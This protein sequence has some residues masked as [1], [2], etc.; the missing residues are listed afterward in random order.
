[1]DN[2]SS[3]QNAKSKERKKEKRERKWWERCGKGQCVRGGTREEC[4]LELK[5]A[6]NGGIM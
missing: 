4:T 3:L 6:S 2:R 1:M 5:V